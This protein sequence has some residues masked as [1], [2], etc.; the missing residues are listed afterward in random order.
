V[1]LD[2]TDVDLHW[3]VRHAVHDASHHLLDVKRLRDDL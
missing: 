3:I 2:G 1:M